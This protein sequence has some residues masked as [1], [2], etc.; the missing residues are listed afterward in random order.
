MAVRH[1]AGF[2]PHSIEDILRHR[3]SA[4]PINLV[5]HSLQDTEQREYMNTEYRDTLQEREYMNTSLETI[6]RRKKMRTTFTGRQIYQLEKMFETKK[7]LNAGERR[8]LSR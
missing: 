2:T 6:S 3:D 1:R 5:K 4:A 8:D 7:Y